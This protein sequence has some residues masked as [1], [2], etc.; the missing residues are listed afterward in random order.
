MIW[1]IRGGN[2]RHIALFYLD[3][4]EGLLFLFL[5]K[6]WLIKL[7]LYLCNGKFDTFL[8][9]TM[10]GNTQKF[11]GGIHLCQGLIFKR[12]KQSYYMDV[13]SQLLVLVLDQYRFTKRHHMYFVIRI[14]HELSLH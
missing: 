9:R 4:E 5:S 3:I 6:T 2:G 1:K 7:K 10:I 11:Q 14:L 8:F 13:R 12:K